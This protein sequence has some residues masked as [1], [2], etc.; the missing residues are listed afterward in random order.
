MVYLK[1]KELGIVTF[2]GDIYTGNPSNFTIALNHVELARHYKVKLKDVYDTGFIYEDG[3]E[4]W[5]YIDHL[6]SEV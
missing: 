4:Y 2:D 6:A 5:R 1:V 3:S